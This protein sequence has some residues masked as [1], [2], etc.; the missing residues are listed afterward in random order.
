MP[1]NHP[2]L[3]SKGSLLLLVVD[4]EPTIAKY[5]GL[6]L[7][8]EGYRVL[9]AFSAEQGWELFQQAVPPVRAVVNI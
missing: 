8:R 4:D 3:A 5:M 6:V 7:G 9:T 1:T 2:T